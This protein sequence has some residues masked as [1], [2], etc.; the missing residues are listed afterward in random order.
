MNNN[1]SIGKNKFLISPGL[2]NPR[3]LIGVIN[4]IMPKLKAIYIDSTDFCL[5]NAK[6]Y[7]PKKLGGGG[8]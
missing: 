4:P 8:R 2:K 5:L 3:I 7:T 1:K 6:R